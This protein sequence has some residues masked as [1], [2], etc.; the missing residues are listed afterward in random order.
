M[1]LQT[2]VCRDA[3]ESKFRSEVVPVSKALGAQNPGGFVTRQ[4][5]AA[6]GRL[7]QKHAAGVSTVR[8]LHSD[9]GNASPRTVKV[10]LRR[11]FESQMGPEVHR[12]R[13]AKVVLAV[14]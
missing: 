11:G 3:R 14:A 8:G 1:C 9:A 4:P 7:R 6:E 10:E 2:H 13:V 5:A 12:R